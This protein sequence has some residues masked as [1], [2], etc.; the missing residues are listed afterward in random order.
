MGPVDLGPENRPPIAQDDPRSI[1]PKDFL[2]LEPLEN[3]SDPDGD[4]L[5]I[6]AV[7]T[8]AN[9]QVMQN[10]NSVA[11]VPDSGF[12]G[13]ERIEYTISDGRGGE[14]SATIIVKVDED[15]ILISPP[16]VSMNVNSEV[17]FTASNGRPPYTFSLVAGEGAI[18]LASGAFFSAAAPGRAQILVTDADNRTAM[19]EADFGT[20]EFWYL[21]GAEE[22]DIFNQVRRSTDGVVWRN[23]GTLIPERY[24]HGAVVYRD[25]IWIAG[26]RAFSGLPEN[27]QTLD[28]VWNSNNGITWLPVA[29]LPYEVRGAELVVFN[30]RLF[31]IG[32]RDGNDA[33]RAD[34][35]TSID[36]QNWSQVGVL[37]AARAYG[38]AEIFNGE[39]WYAGGRINSSLVNTVWSSADGVTW[40]S[41]PSL[42]SSRY[43]GAMRS[44]ASR[45]WYVGGATLS[46]QGQGN[47]EG[48]ENVWSTDGSSSWASEA[49]LPRPLMGASLL[50]RGGELWVFGGIEDIGQSSARAEVL[51]FQPGAG[52]SYVS[53][54]GQRGRYWG[55][56][57]FFTP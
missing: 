15:P 10:A 47:V 45:L 24:L 18:D 38:S 25:Q 50:A 8:S 35:L 29:S 26:G 21:G 5:E 19:A 2:E 52:W 13:E 1:G 6:I 56:T 22:N 20:G 23:G 3:D 33:Y 14:A 30:Q 48:R 11:Y 44:S 7:G 36:G 28:S 51:R 55:Q 31:L 9:G 16:T 39:I 43:Q 12:F 54:F 32:G 41:R 46:N 34:V 40:S 37:P 53:D 17:T 27:L 57:V 49:D 42:P 4:P